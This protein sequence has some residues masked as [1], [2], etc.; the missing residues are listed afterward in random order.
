MEALELGY[1]NAQNWDWNMG[2]LN[3]KMGERVRIGIWE[4][5]SRNMGRYELEYGRIGAG[6]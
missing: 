3:W 2:G 6:I 1:E 5:K 4:G